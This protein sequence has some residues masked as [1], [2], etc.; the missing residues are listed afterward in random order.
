MADGTVLVIKPENLR[1]LIQAA[2]VEVPIIAPMLAVTA[3][4]DIFLL[5]GGY[6]EIRRT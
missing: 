1:L 2:G 6:N 5:Y 4:V 3:E